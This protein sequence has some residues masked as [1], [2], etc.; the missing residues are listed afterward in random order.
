VV[1]TTPSVPGGNEVAHWREA[2]GRALVPMAVT[3]HGDGPFS[4]RIRTAPLGCLR[5][6]T[7]EADATRVSRTPELIAL[8]PEA[9]VALGVQVS[10]TATLLQEGRRSEVGEGDLVVYDTARPYSFDYPER[11]STHVFPLPRR[12]LGLTDAD[13]RQVCGTVV[14]PSDGFGA[15]LQTFLRTVAA[16]AGSYS[17]AVGGKLANS[18]IDLFA[19][20]VAEVGRRAPAD[21]DGDGEG[22]R[23]RAHLVLRIRDHIDRNLGDPALS[24]DA[25]ARA[26]HISV[27]YL[28]RIFEAEGIT[29]GRLVQ[30]RRLQEC[31]RE[32]AR[33][34]RTAPTV[35]A[36]AQRWGFASPAHF[37]RAFRTAYGVSPREWR[38]LRTTDAPHLAPP[39]VTTTAAGRL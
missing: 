23:A 39:L 35:S 12:V 33:R 6:S 27:R 38:N 26:H 4:G 29:V 17:P 8:S 9:F 16:S 32:L 25:I 2:L 13:V 15:V 28:H 24:P 19:T 10:G 37:S 20:L 22:D 36:V 3:P 34:G 1:L 18:V 7:V 11:F 31:A 14:G 21:G 30:Q 5:V